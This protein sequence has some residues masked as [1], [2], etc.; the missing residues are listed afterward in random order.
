MPVGGSAAGRRRDGPHHRKSRDL[1]TIRW[2]R[3]CRGCGA[4]SRLPP[5]L[6]WS[7]D[8]RTLPQSGVSR[9]SHRDR[10][11]RRAAT[12]WTVS[13]ARWTQP[14][15]IH[16]APAQDHPAEFL[17]DV[18]PDDDVHDPGLVLQRHKDHSPGAARPLAR[19][20]GPPP[21]HAF[22]P[23]RAPLPQP[24]DCPV[25]PDARAGGERMR[26]QRDRRVR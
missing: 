2:S 25:R 23:E 4:A 16:Q 7:G 12:R 9:S 26:P 15:T 11:S 13:P 22:R 19:R 20:R 21:P 5:C 10:S 17:Q 8:V 18:G 14:R 3:G 6:A 1:G 24:T